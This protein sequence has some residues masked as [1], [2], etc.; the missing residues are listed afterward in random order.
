MMPWDHKEDLFNAQKVN[1]KK[2]KKL[3]ILSLFMKL[4]L[5]IQELKDFKFYFQEKLV[6]LNKKLEIKLM[7][8]W[9]NGEKKE[10]LK[11]SL[12]SYL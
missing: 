7:V 1:Y 2:E 9:L 10:K 4:M 8:K 12:V 6:K 3:Y 11:L 5:L